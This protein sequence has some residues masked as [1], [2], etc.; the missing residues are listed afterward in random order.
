[1]NSITVTGVGKCYRKSRPPSPWQ[2]L[3]ARLGNKNAAESVKRPREIWA[4]KDVSFSAEPGTI[5]GI[6]GP[7]GAGKTTLL[8]V[9]ARITPPTEGRIVGRGSVA[10]LLELGAGLQPELTARE[11][12]E[13]YAAWHGISRTDVQQRVS[14]IVEFAEIGEFLESPL[15]HFSSGMYVRLAFSIAINMQPDILLADEVLA[16]GDIAFQERCLQRVQE[17]GAA[18]MTVLFVSHDMAAIQ[19]LCNRVIWLNAGHVVQDGNPEAV[20]AQYESAAWT[21]TAGSAKRG[22]KGSHASAHGEILSIRLLSGTGREIGAARPDEEVYLSL[23]YS[24]LTPG[25]TARCFMNITT[26]GI[27]AFR[28]VQP[29]ELEVV[30]AGIFRASVRIPPDLLADTIYTV[31]AGI[32]IYVDG[33]ETIIV[34]DYGLSFRVYADDEGARRTLLARGVNQGSSWSGAVMPRLEWQVTR[35][36]DVVTTP[37]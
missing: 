29:D 34:Q 36:R 4:L 37:V 13:L 8:K 35:E 15:K 30:E 23:T 10:P 25:A 14:D 22:K 2:Q 32:R 16:V 20:V 18:G 7:N 31:K 21:L 5:L 12:I 11:N 3:L 33:R 26:R 9:L 24:L 17:A 28:A 19:R 6:I 27:L 1:M